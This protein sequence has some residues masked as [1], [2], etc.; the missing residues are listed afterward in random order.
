MKDSWTRGLDESHAL[1][2]RKD[3]AGSSLLRKRFSYLI[4]DKRNS[5]ITSDESREGYDC[6][7]WSFKQADSVGYRR[8]LREVMDLIK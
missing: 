3:Y 8:A 6:P 5:S 1:E 4:E 2:I 7:N